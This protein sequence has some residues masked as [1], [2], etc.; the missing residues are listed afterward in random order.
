MARFVALHENQVVNV[1]HIIYMRHYKDNGSKDGLGK[2]RWC[3]LIA[4]YGE[5]DTYR[6]STKK[7]M[8]SVWNQLIGN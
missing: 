4:S 2:R 7:K 1:D 6:Y 8:D 3:I 5:T